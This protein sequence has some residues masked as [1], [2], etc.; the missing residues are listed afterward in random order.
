MQWIPTDEDATCADE[1]DEL[2]DVVLAEFEE[3]DD[4]LRED[5]QRV[6]TLVADAVTKLYDG[7]TSLNEQ[8]SAQDT[9]LQRM[10]VRVDRRGA[11][12]GGGSD[13]QQFAAQASETLA[14]FLDH[15]LLTS[16][17]SMDIFQSMEELSSRMTEV[18]RLV[19]G[20]DRVA[21]QTKMLSLNA[22]IE[23]ARAGHA[24]AGFGVVAQEVKRLSATTSELNLAIMSSVEAAKGNVG[25]VRKVVEEIAATD[26]TFAFNA[27]EHVDA[28]VADAA[29]VHT[30]MAERV[31]EATEISRHI[32]EKVALS[33]RALQFDD[34]V[35]QL[36]AHLEQRLDTMSCF[37]G[38][39]T[40]LVLES[41]DPVLRARAS[42]LLHSYA[43]AAPAAAVRP[44]EQENLDAGDVTLF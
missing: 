33:V 28:M 36:M 27:K 7:F 10:L 24:G 16:R 20:I 38:E 4:M 9:L 14:R 35:S 25:Y 8:L 43:S 18:G 29:E 12:S 5:M 34:I 15:I 32:S 30:F 42:A 13:M 37:C 40:E 44:V 3:Q 21:N 2:G 22:A 11:A 31:T 39:L 17:N 26:T 6:R 19:S 23:A 41:D 1:L